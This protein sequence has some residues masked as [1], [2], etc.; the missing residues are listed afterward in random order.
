MIYSDIALMQEQCPS[1]TSLYEAVERYRKALELM[2]DVMRHEDHATLRDLT[3]LRVRYQA[4][5]EAL[6]FND[7][8]GTF[9]QDY[10]RRLLNIKKT[11]SG[12]V[13]LLLRHAVRKLR[14]SQ[15]PF[16]LFY[17]VRQITV[18]HPAIAPPQFA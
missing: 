18:T 15:P 14:P 6:A 3:E 4:S 8:Y 12:L 2:V 16:S 5:L 10:Q 7:E 1:M 11:I 13:Q 9:Y 17:R